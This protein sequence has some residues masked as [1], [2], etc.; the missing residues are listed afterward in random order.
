MV[1]QF[2]QT[3]LNT[4]TTAA[5][6]PSKSF[7]VTLIR[8][9]E[10]DEN[11]ASTIQGQMNTHLN[12]CGINQALSLAATFPIEEFQLIYSSDLSR[13]YQT[14]HILLNK[15]PGSY[16][17]RDS[18]TIREDARLRARNF[19]D[20]E[21]KP[22]DRLLFEALGQGAGKTVTDFTPL[23]GE[24]SIEVQQRV[25]EFLQH[26]L[27]PEVLHQTDQG[28]ESP[29]S[30]PSPSPSPSVLNVLIVTHA[31][32]ISEVLAYFESFRPK[33][34]MAAS[35]KAPAEQ[36]MRTPN[37]SVSTFTVQYEASGEGQRKARIVSAECYQSHG[38]AHLT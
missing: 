30:S 11:A 16:L 7:T 5:T 21:G 34:S 20:L 23:G 8:H 29:S 31:V 12:E 38:V 17:C 9:G 6:A 24:S 3:E 14:A 27:L 32:V 4:G 15:S 18:T 26:R 10:T 37:T 33:A 22:V 28:Q 2:K 1:Q 35:S 13:A 25:L 36:T 19:G